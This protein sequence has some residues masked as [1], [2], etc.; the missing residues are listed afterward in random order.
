MHI[1]KSQ[2]SAVKEEH[3]TQKHEQAPEYGETD[4]NLY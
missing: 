2:E 4:S 3:Y 1:S